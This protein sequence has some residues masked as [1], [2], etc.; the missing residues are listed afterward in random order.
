MDGR[1]ATDTPSLL[2][3]MI[4]AYAAGRISWREIRDQSGV[5]DFNA[6]LTSLAENGLKLPRAPRERPSNS[7]NLMREILTDVV[8]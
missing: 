6:M 7:K 4:H 1:D 2:A 3:D 5:E 8:A